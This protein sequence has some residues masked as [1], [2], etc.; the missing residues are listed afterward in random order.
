MITLS[1]ADSALKD[2]YLDVVNAQLNSDVSPFY[3]AIVKTSEN[4]YGKDVKMTIVKGGMG[5]VRASSESEALPTARENR[6][7][8]LTQSLKNIYGTIEISDK[9]IRASADSSG[10]FVNLLNA[11]MEGLISD[12]KASFARMLYGDGS[13]LLTTVVSKVSSKQLQVKEVKTFFVGMKINIITSSGMYV[14]TITAVDK[15]NNLITLGDSVDSYNILGGESIGIYSATNK[16]I[17]G[18]ASIFDS[19]I[20]YGISKESDSF[21]KPYITTIERS[22]LTEDDLLKTIDE[23]EEESGGKI[24]MILCSYATKRLITKLFDTSRHI[25]NSTDIAAGCTSL[26]INEVPVYADKFCPESRIYFLN[27]DDFVLNQLCDWSWLEDENGRVLKQVAG[28]ASYSATLVKYADLLCKR[29]CGQG[30][31]N[32]TD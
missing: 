23:I 16:E 13:G 10:A 29:P 24:N 15:V 11:E 22:A 20:I 17:S 21:L 2:Y 26:Y 32:L 18:L 19:S 1:S 12:A 3:N 30:L 8:T 6:Y 28:K 4:V 5:A 31:I 25:I 7:F 27:T 9:A 14:S